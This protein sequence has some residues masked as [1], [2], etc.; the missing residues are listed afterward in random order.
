MPHHPTEEE[1]DSHIFDQVAKESKDSTASDHAI[2]TEQAVTNAHNSKGP[3]IPESTFLSPIPR[4]LL[5]NS[6]TR[7][8]RGERQGRIES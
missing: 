1:T 2:H 5:I 4:L 7:H 8:A 3:Q 6:T